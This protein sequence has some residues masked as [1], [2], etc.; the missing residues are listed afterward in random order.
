MKA[1]EMKSAKPPV[2]QEREK[3]I[4]F[5]NNK[6]NKKNSFKNNEFWTIIMNWK[7]RKKNL[8]IH[9]AFWFEV[10]GCDFKIWMRIFNIK[11]KNENK[12]E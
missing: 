10:E 4:I 9:L 8:S 7:R 6:N 11:T 5:E 1:A 12:K 3:I 2:W